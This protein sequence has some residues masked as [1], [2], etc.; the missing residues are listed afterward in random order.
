MI[1]PHKPEPE[2]DQGD[3]DLGVELQEESEERGLEGDERGFE[4]EGDED[5]ELDDAEHAIG[6]DAPNGLEE[7]VDEDE[8][9]AEDERS[10]LD[11][12]EADELAADDELDEDAERWTDGSEPAG[13][14]GFDDD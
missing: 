14:E 1:A 8:V 12:A 5:L 7:E 13:D 2:T 9:L 4:P 11:E 6:L 3:D 10:W